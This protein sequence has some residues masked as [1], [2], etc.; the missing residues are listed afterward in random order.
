ME[1]FSYHPEN[2]EIDPNG[3]HPA[4]KL[5]GEANDTVLGESRTT[6]FFTCATTRRTRGGG[7]QLAGPGAS[8]SRIQE[9]L[10]YRE[11]G[12]IGRVSQEEN[13]SLSTDVPR[14]MLEVSGI[15]FDDIQPGSVRGHEHRIDLDTA[16]DLKAKIYPLRGDS[17]IGAAREE[18]TR[19]PNGDG[20]E[21]V[22]DRQR[23]PG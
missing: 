10:I 14:T 5:Y 22:A 11:Q 8:G 21:K 20:A 2:M 7:D 13:R 12:H 17:Q 4:A 6:I 16:K 3:S 15:F 23:S 19:F 1:T 18:I 9:P